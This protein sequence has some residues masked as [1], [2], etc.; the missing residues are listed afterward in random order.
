MYST[1][2]KMKYIHTHKTHRN[3]KPVIVKDQV[4][5]KAPQ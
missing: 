1:D 3:N 5:N 2:M 4:H